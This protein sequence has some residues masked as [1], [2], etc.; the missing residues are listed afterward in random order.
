MNAAIL[1]LKEFNSRSGDAREIFIRYSPAA[2]QMATI[3]R[4][5]TVDGG[6]VAPRRRAK[7]ATSRHTEPV[8]KDSAWVLPVSEELRSL[9]REFG[10]QR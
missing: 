10:E 5:I 4:V 2:P 6:T 7:I 3:E 1:S 8:S 9:A